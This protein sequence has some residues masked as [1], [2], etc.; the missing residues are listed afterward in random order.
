M[1][2]KGSEM[3]QNLTFIFPPE[4]MSSS[5]SEL[6]LILWVGLMSLVVVACEFVE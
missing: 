3:S 2:S 5:D 4:M 6:S 1:I